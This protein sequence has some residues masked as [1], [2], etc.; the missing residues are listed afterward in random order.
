[1]KDRPF[2]LLAPDDRRPER[3]E[4]LAGRELPP[5]LGSHRA[6]ARSFQPDADLVGAVNNVPL[7]VGAP[8]LLTGSRG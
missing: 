3:R 8:L 2:E 6:A 1:M 7:A 4:A 5:V